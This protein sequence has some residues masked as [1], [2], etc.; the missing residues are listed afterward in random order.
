[1]APLSEDVI[2]ILLSV[3]V[4][5][6]IGA[7]REYRAKTAGFRTIILI[8]VGATLFTILS[9]K[10]GRYRDPTRI[11]AS[12]VSGVGFLGAGAILRG[13]E[14]IVGLTTASS[15]WVA[16]ALGMGIGGG[17]YALAIFAAIITFVVLML[18]PKIEARLD[19]ASDARTYRVISP[20]SD[21]LFEELEGAIRSCGLQVRGGKRV[22]SHEKM[23]CTWS[24]FGSPEGHREFVNKLFKHPEVKEFD[25]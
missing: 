19:A 3:L 5:G 11:A 22:K 12:I 2:K 18:F 7:E 6:L 21:S 17:Q 9:I 16:A 8:C 23:I 4:G 10:L 24:V 1:M 13:P 20:I 15:I 14:R 25:V